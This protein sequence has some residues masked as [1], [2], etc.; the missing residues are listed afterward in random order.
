MLDTIDVMYAQLTSLMDRKIFDP[1]EVRI[2]EEYIDRMI[3]EGVITKDQAHK[4][5]NISRVDTRFVTLFGIPIKITNEVET[6]KFVFRGDEKI[7][8]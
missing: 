4:A 3:A 2:S 8:Y 6:Y 7:E 5:T 1:Y